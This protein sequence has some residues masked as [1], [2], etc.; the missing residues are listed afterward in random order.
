MVGWKY[1]TTQ[2]YFVAAYLP[3]WDLFVKSITHSGRSRYLGDLAADTALKDTA[4]GVPGD[5]WTTSKGTTSTVNI[6]TNDGRVLRAND[7]R[8]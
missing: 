8:V 7:T 5:W 2:E 1:P 6:I 4:T 3:D